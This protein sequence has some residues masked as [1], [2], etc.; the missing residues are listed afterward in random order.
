MQRKRNHQHST[1]QHSTV[2]HSA[3]VN[4]LCVLWVFFSFSVLRDYSFLFSIR[5]MYFIHIRGYINYNKHSSCSSFWFYTFSSKQQE[6]RERAR[7]RKAHAVSSIRSSSAIKLKWTR[8]LFVLLLSSQNESVLVCSLLFSPQMVWNIF[9]FLWLS[10]RNSQINAQNEIVTNQSIEIQVLD[11]E[12]W[13][14]NNRSIL[15]TWLQWIVFLWF[16]FAMSRK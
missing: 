11:S 15:L 12:L 2:Q 13:L 7:E 1:A 14:S 3:P 5:R 4:V 16:R 6:S 9:F 8:F 10:Y